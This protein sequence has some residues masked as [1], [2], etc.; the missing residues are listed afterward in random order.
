MTREELINEAVAKALG[1]KPDIED[2]CWWIL[3]DGNL[4]DLSFSGLYW[5]DIHTYLFPE[6]EK[7]G[8]WPEFARFLFAGKTIAHTIAGYTRLVFLA[9]NEQ[10]CEAFLRCTGNWTEEMEAK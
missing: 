7:R 3:P 6:I 4:R 8:L 2:S 9:T 1:W 10:I 5:M